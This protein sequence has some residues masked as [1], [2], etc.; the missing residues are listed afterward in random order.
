MSTQT[1][2]KSIPILMYHSISDQATS[3]FRRFTVKPALFNEHM[4]YLYEHAYTPITITQLIQALSGGNTLLP[5]KPVALTFDDGFLDFYTQA[6]PV[7]LRYHFVATLYIVTAFL[8]ETS[9]WLQKEG[10][11]TRPLLTWDQV[12]SIHQAGIECGGH[13]HTHPALDTLPLSSARAEIVHC[14]RLL[15]E[16]LGHEVLSFAYPFGYHTTRTKQLVR[17]AGYTSACAV[18]Y[19]MSSQ[20]TD[21]FALSRLIISADT[22]VNELAT[23]LIQ[24][25]S[26]LL[27]FSKRIATPVWR[28]A[29]RASATLTKQTY[30]QEGYSAS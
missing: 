16:R 6:L 26:P 27:T 5:E 14:K 18:K 3:K 21:P 9:R 23:L 12:V 17:D 2:K 8:N 7:L 20:T 15:E 19:A 10:E 25:S 28:L 1:F 29:R 13:T 24:G 11:A 22:G 4:A 30:S